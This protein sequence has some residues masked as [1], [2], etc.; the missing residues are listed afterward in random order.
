MGIGNFFPPFVEKLQKTY[1]IYV[2]FNGDQMKTLEKNDYNMSQFELLLSAGTDIQID[3]D[4]NYVFDWNLDEETHQIIMQILRVILT[5]E[6]TN[7]VV[8]DA[9]L[10]YDELKNVVPVDQ[11]VVKKVHCSGLAIT[12][13]SII[14]YEIWVEGNLEINKEKLGLFING[15]YSRH[16]RLEE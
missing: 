2:L 3:P 13:L 1:Y 14:L 6:Y 4:K 5:D 9:I 7:L 10:F 15:M 11:R 16:I 8:G 12:A